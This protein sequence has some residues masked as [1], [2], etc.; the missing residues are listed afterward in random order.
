MKLGSFF[1][2]CG[3]LDLGFIQAG[4]DVV[5]ANDIDKHACQV[6][7]KNIGEII[8]DSIVNLD[9]IDLEK[10]DIITGG[11]PCQP[12]STAGNRKSVLDHRGNLFFETLRLVKHHKPKVVVFENVR[13]LLSS[14]NESGG[15]LLKDIVDV[16]GDI[17]GEVG[18]DVNYKLLKS[19]DYEVPQ[20]RFRVIIVGIRKDLKIDFKFPYPVPTAIE[21]LSV[22]NILGNTKGLKDNKHWELSPQQKI[23][24]P[25]ITEGGSWKDIPYDILPPRFKKIRSD[26][27]KYGSPNFY[28]RFS[29]NEINGTITASSQPEN[30]G[31]LHPLEDRRYTVREIARIQSFP[32]D[33]V[34]ELPSIQANYK[35]IG[36]AVPPKM[37][38]HIAMAIKDQVFD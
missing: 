19:S 14:K 37:A 13:G 23:L 4:Y 22:A 15:S 26:M 8:H 7:E 6:Y 24:V 33:F 18:Y 36:N 5:W 12:F 9:P 32:D 11:F 25:H 29:R 38:Y 1:S 21:D 3:G 31:I 17:D 20:N 2:G 16:L 30:C 35:V 34:F 10:V 27:K 28:R